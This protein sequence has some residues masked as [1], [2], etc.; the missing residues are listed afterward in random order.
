MFFFSFQDG[1]DL[2]QLQAHDNSIA[3]IRILSRLHY[4]RIELIR[5][6]TY[7]SYTSRFI[8]ILLG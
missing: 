5:I 8:S 6:A 7:T 2:V 4:P 1:F 3:S